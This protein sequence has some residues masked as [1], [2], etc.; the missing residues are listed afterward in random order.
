MHRVDDARVYRWIS[1]RIP[2]ASAQRH[3]DFELLLIVLN[4]ILRIERAAIPHRLGDQRR[5][6]LA[7][8]I[9]NSRH[10]GRKRQTP[11][12][13]LR[14]KAEKRSHRGISVGPIVLQRPRKNSSFRLGASNPLHIHPLTPPTHIHSRHQAGNRTFPRLN[15]V[16]G[17]KSACHVPRHQVCGE[18]G[19]PPTPRHR[20][21]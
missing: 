17:L 1:G 13:P 18:G 10:I 4:P 20:D 3:D 11:D 19:E 8:I 7:V 6:H 14:V 16:T 15:P 9:V 12:R 2:K 5:K 21:L